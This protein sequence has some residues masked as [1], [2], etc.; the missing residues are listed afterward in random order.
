M[1]QGLPYFLVNVPI[2][3]NL[4]HLNLA[5]TGAY[6]KNLSVINVQSYGVRS[7]TD[8]YLFENGADHLFDVS[9]DEGELRPLSTTFPWG[10]WL[11]VRRIG[12][13][14]VHFTN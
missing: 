12:A 1:V 3:P 10:S 8:A 2:S 6:D 14:A 4:A 7:D 5:S 9:R 13:Q 11:R